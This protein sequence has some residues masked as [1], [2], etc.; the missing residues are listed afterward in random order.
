M[1]KP[2]NPCPIT[3]KPL[4]AGYV[5][6]PTLDVRV[7]GLASKVA[8]VMPEARRTQLGLSHAPTTDG[9]HT[10]PRSDCLL[11]TSIY[12]DVDDMRDTLYT[13]GAELVRTFLPGAS[14]TSL[15]NTQARDVDWHRWALITQS[16]ADA[17]L[18]WHQAPTF[19]DE[20]E[21][22]VNRAE[23]LTKP[24][25]N[26][27]LLRC[28]QCYTIDYYPNDRHYVTCP[29]CH[30]T[31]QPTVAR[32]AMLASAYARPLTR[33][34]LHTLLKSA[35]YP[36]KRATIDKWI[37]RR[38]LTARATNPQRFNPQEALQLAQKQYPHPHATNPACPKHV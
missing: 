10:P 32:Q 2:T 15:Y 30:S 26:Q 36:V 25:H 33:S 22:A 16:K 3:G 19:L 37:T 34:Q 1:S 35:G 12:E 24:H 5:L 28:P 38:K 23:R 21:Y 14:P 4:P 7:R 13:W 18:H 20:C 6:H 11:R 29:S 9:A 27:D 31:Y 8:T 17:I